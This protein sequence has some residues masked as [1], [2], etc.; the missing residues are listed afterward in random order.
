MK[1]EDCK[2][3]FA[4]DQSQIQITGRGIC[5]KANCVQRDDART[6]GDETSLAHALTTVVGAFGYEMAINQ[7]ETLPEF[8][9]IQF[10]SKKQE[11]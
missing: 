2:H 10:E 4:T 1:C 7:L 11:G 3:W 9:C 6:L 8:G 5:L